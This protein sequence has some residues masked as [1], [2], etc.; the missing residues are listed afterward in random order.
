M[1]VLALLTAPAHGGEYGNPLRHTYYVDD[2]A[3]SVCSGAGRHCSIIECDDV[4]TGAGCACLLVFPNGARQPLSVEQCRAASQELPHLPA[5]HFGTLPVV[6]PN[7]GCR[8]HS[9][10]AVTPTECRYRC[11]GTLSV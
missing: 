9:K 6:Q 4:R 5:S 2:P 10:E 3:N 8:W 11:E 7:A 1:L